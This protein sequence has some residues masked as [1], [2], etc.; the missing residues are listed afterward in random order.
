MIICNGKVTV[1]VPFGLDYFTSVA[2]V[3]HDTAVAVVLPIPNVHSFNEDL[4][5]SPI[6]AMWIRI[7]SCDIEA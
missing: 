7:P 6:S 4:S 2:I 1:T 5:D 3:V